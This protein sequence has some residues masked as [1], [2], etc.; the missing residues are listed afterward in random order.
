MFRLDY[1]ECFVYSVAMAANVNLSIG[2]NGV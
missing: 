2:L 1:G